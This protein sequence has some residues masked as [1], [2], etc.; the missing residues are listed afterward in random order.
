MT[1]ENASGKI[2]PWCVSRA[3]G[4]VEVCARTVQ[5]GIDGRGNDLDLTAS[6]AAMLAINE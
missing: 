4:V 6:S 2:L 1:A 3:S 5:T